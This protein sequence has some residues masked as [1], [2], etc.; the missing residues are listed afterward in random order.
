MCKKDSVKSCIASEPILFSLPL[1][2]CKLTR[3]LLTNIESDYICDIRQELNVHPR[4]VCYISLPSGT[5]ISENLLHKINEQWNEMIDNNID[6]IVF[7]Y[8]S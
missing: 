5:N 4:M 8:D 2:C 1:F 3:E 7:Y 6:N